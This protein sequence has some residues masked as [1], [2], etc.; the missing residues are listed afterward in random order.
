MNAPPNTDTASPQSDGD[1]LHWLTNETRDE[2]FLD[3]IFTE[4]CLRIQRSGIPV[5]RASLHML[6]HHPQWL[7]AR[8]MWAEGMREAELARVDYDV[9]ER[10][11]DLIAGKKV[12]V[13]TTP[14]KSGVFE[15]HVLL[16]EKDGVIPPL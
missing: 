9:R 12:F 7:G 14:T 13:L 10:S 6:I 2:R 16:V 4:L 15:A 5:K 1:V 8:I 3:N 11:E